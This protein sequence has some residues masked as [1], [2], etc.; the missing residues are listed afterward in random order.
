M[1][2]SELYHYGVMGM[3]WGVRRSVS[4]S[5]SNMPLR[6]KA[7][8][9]ELKADKLTKKAEK[10]HSTYDL[11]KSNNAAKKAS[12]F[13]IEADK[14]HKKA[15]KID[16]DFKKSIYEKR[17]SKLEYKADKKQIKANRLS[18]TTGYGAK[19]MKYSIKSDKAAKKAAK[20][21]MKLANNSHYI[22]MMKR[23]INTVESD[24]KYKSI[25]EDVRRQYNTV[26]G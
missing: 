14:L 23:K 9:Y 15:L 20:A 18:K 13:R 8:K 2:E 11:N 19:A 16:S 21:K 3:K 24:P 4:K 5:K 17:A 10:E 22:E 6:K 1:T 12:N 7:V 25:V 26:F